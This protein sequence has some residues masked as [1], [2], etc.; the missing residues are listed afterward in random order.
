MTV[1]WS[2]HPTSTQ[3]LQ[4]PGDSSGLLSPAN[5]A[6]ALYTLSKQ[7]FSTDTRSS[8]VMDG[9]NLLQLCQGVLQL[10]LK[11]DLT[12]KMM[13]PSKIFSTYN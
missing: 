7:I 13:F 4:S 6:A 11:L 12:L 9:G 1:I 10:T 5:E 3:L 8:A 2:A